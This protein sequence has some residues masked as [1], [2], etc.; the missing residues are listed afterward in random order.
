MTV[1]RNIKQL[2]VEGGD[3]PQCPIADDANVKLLHGEKIGM[4]IN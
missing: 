4:E 2:E 1:T 3:M